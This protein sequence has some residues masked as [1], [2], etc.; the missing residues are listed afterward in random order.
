MQ[1][2]L[3]CSGSKGRSLLPWYRAVHW[4]Q[5][6]LVLVAWGDGA[7]DGTRETAGRLALAG[8]GLDAD[9]GDRPAGRL[10][11]SPRRWSYLARSGRGSDDHAKSHLQVLKV[12]PCHVPQGTVR[13]ALLEVPANRQVSG[14]AFGLRSQR[15][16]GPNP[17]GRTIFPNDS[18]EFC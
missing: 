7:R 6:V 5:R 3:M 12:S 13:R 15:I 1:P 16:V 18:C 9:A 4:T 14:P 11:R 2:P 10:T 17:T 8:G